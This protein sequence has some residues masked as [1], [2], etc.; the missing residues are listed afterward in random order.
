MIQNSKGLDKF[1]NEKFYENLKYRTPYDM[2]IKAVIV[3]TCLIYDR[4]LYDG[5]GKRIKKPDPSL[6]RDEAVNYIKSLSEKAKETYNDLW[7]DS[8]PDELA[9]L[10]IRSIKRLIE[11]A[12]YVHYLQEYL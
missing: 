12:Y 4:L 3:E 7:N 6:S 2:V 1:F 8:H 10:H 11:G 9:E 5:D